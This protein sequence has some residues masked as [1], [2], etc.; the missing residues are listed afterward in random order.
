MDGEHDLEYADHRRLLDGHRARSR[1][2][3]LHGGRFCCTSDTEDHSIGAT[4]AWSA[5]LPD[6]HDSA[7]RGRVGLPATC[8]SHGALSRRE[9][10]Q[11]Q[12]PR[13]ATMWWRWAGHCGRLCQVEPWRWI[14][15]AVQWRDAWWRRLRRGHREHG[16]RRWGEPG[17]EHLTDA[18]HE[19][20]ENGGDEQDKSSLGELPRAG[21][22]GP[23]R[24]QSQHQRR[25]GQEVVVS[26]A[27]GR[28]RRTAGRMR[29]AGSE[30]PKYVEAAARGQLRVSPEKGDN[31]GNVRWVA[32][33]L[34]CACANSERSDV[35]AAR[36][37]RSTTF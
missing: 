26:E 25:L 29:R 10:A 4:A 24:L 3:G 35:H 15:R 33:S 11:R 1:D 5:H 20:L 2:A 16:K 19:S 18:G 28:M 30:T 8:A 31:R 34:C 36:G 13:E 32:S 17:Q 23:G 22:L 27:A 9:L 14:S 12:H 37:L 21:G 6:V 7:P